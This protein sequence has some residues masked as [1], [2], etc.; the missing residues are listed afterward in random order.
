MG[1]FIV[2]D[3]NGQQQ[4]I[5]E[6]SPAMQ[7]FD[8]NLRSYWIKNYAQPSASLNSTEL[9]N[10]LTQDTLP[11]KVSEASSNA[12]K[13]A[14][15]AGQ[16]DILSTTGELFKNSA[17]KGKISPDIYNQQQQAA[18]ALGIDNATFDSNFAGFR[19]QNDIRYN[20]SD[21]IAIQKSL[22]DFVTAIKSYADVE[23]SGQAG[24]IPQALENIPFLGSLLKQ[25][26]YTKATAHD[27]LLNQIKGKLLKAA[28]AGAGSTVRGSVTELGY[29]TDLLPHSG[30]S[31]QTANDK[32][33]R[34][35]SFMQS[36][37]G[38]SLDDILSG[39]SNTDQQYGQ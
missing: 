38:V 26:Q 6:N 27:A 28:G 17:V 29:A 19:N 12:T 8:P 9:N 32:L 34:L 15:G 3:K 1:Y 25:S 10:Q 23:K 4:Q 39:Q 18:G 5:D 22:P 37:Y 35:D 16:A 11:S 13:A 30:D 36:S 33:S 14:Q 7:Q 21:N 31:K 24:P 20:T 2:K